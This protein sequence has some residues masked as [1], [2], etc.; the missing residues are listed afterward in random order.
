MSSIA[1]PSA[2]EIEREVAALR[3]IRRRSSQQGPG[4]IPLDPDLPPNGLVSASAGGYWDNYGQQQTLSETAA[5]PDALGS[6]SDEG[7]ADADDPSHLFWVPAHLHPELAPGEFRSFLKE[8][9]RTNVDGTVG[10]LSRSFSGSSST[11]LGRKKSMLSKQ[12]KPTPNDHVED[13]RVVTVKRNRS[14]IYSSAGP[15]LTIS[16]LQK[17]EELAEEAAKSDDPSKLRSMLRRSLS[18]NVAPSCEFDVFLCPRRTRVLLTWRNQSST[19]WTICPMWMTPTLRSSSPDQVKFCD[20]LR[21]R[22]SG[23]PICRVMAAD[24]DF[25]RHVEADAPRPKAIRSLTTDMT[26]RPMMRYPLRSGLARRT[27]VR[28][29]TRKRRSFSTPTGKGG[30]L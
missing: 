6:T 3:D 12:Y 24:I 11:G 28:C 7:S 23:S 5:T 14:S 20:V 4:S 2:F 8:H 16:D 15:T 30:T 25:L 13:E 27:I 10:L 9:T 1:P 18:L 21:G 19:R 17:L 22:R 29:R 26:P